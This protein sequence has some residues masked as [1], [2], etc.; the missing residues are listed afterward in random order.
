[1]CL[2]NVWWSLGHL[3][4]WGKRLATES[5]SISWI[6][7]KIFHDKYLRGVCWSRW[8]LVSSLWP[9]GCF[10]FW[11]RF[12]D[13]PCRLLSLR[14]WWPSLDLLFALLTFPCLV[15]DSPFD[16]ISPVPCSLLMVL[17]ILAQFI[18][19]FVSI[20]SIGNHY[21]IASDGK[22]KIHFG[23]LLGRYNNGLRNGTDG[24]RLQRIDKRNEWFD[25]G[26]EGIW[27][28]ILG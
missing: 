6:C 28:E 2:E 14:E 1:M 26:W 13:P 23:F 27:Q 16:A 15:N 5:L 8:V 3:L 4:G 18:L 12:L 9:I 17:I 24:G 20:A 25:F 21:S 10:I 19:H 11:R 7:D 22:S